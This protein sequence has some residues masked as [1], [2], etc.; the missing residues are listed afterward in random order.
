MKKIFLMVIIL[1]GNSFINSNIAQIE[2]PSF[3]S[4]NM[5]LQQETEA[6]IWGWAEKGKELN[7]KCSWDNGEYS[8][9]AVGGNV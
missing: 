3:I 5:V 4:D 9:T 6:L 8:A 1:I 2:F 7:I